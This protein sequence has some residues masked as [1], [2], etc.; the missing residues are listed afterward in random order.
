VA[1]LGCCPLGKTP[2]DHLLL[3]RISVDAKRNEFTEGTEVAA[4]VGVAFWPHRIG[5]QYYE[6]SRVSVDRSDKPPEVPR[7]LPRA[8][9]GECRSMK[10]H[11]TAAHRV[12]LS[13]SQRTVCASPL[14]H[15]RICDTA[16]WSS[17][18]SSARRGCSCDHRRIVH[19]AVVSHAVESPSASRSRV[20]QLAALRLRFTSSSRYL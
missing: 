3:L 20:S 17:G 19:R 7:E 1:H 6:L 15:S 11:M 18:D 8:E 4:L 14:R 2:Q 16:A 13:A 12:A 10:S 5:Y 9:V